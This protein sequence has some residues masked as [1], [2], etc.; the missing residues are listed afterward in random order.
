MKKNDIR[1]FK[2][3]S[4]IPKMSLYEC[5]LSFPEFAEYAANIDLGEIPKAKKVCIFGVG[6]SSIAGDIISAYA[7]DCSEIPVPNISTNIVPGWVDS[8]TNVVLVSYSGGNLIINTVYDKVKNKGCRIYCIA[9]DGFLK[10]KC[11]EDGNVLL[12]MPDG[13]MS[14]SSLGF[15]L[16]LLSSLIEKMGIC[17]V[18]EK[19]L[20]TIP[21]IKEY[22]DSLFK[23]ER[24]YNLK[25]KLH[26]SVIA[27]YG[28]PDFRASFRRWKMSLNED[29]SMPSFCGELP[30]FNHN[31]IVG[32]ANHYQND[33]DL[34]IVMLRGKYKNDVL[35]EIIDKTMEVLEEYKRHVIDIRILGSNPIEKNMRAI[36]L[37]DY[38]S[39]LINYEERNPMSWRESL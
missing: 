27:I 11:T 16:G 7:D 3:L 6:E 10:R 17:N 35:T 28:S 19:L 25:F 36:L 14:R 24:I 12:Q 4:D 23:D 22:R 1:I 26:D 9:N 38:I 13:L 5:L 34:K 37:A 20:E 15:E 30:E 2:D 32:W 33:D 18:R 21:L 29:M 31:E 8:E 39:Q